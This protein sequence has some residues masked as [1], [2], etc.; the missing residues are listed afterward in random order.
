MLRPRRIADPVFKT[1]AAS[2]YLPAFLKLVLAEGI[3]PSSPML[4]A[5]R[6]MIELRERLE[7]GCPG[8]SRTSTAPL[9]KRVDYYYPT[10]QCKNGPRGRICT[11]DH[12]VPSG[13]CCCYT[14]RGLPRRLEGAGDLVLWKR[15]RSSLE[16]VSGKIGG[17]E[18]TCTLSLPADNGLLRS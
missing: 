3:S 16:H 9:N 5:S 14:T 7:T 12:S 10:G 11:C 1:G 17:P 13:A 4:E 6:S 15:R 18:G 8:W 2:L